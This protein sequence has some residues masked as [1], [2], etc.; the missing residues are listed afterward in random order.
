MAL[1]KFRVYLRGIKFTIVTESSAIRATINNNDIQPQ[2]A[3]WWVYLQDYITFDIVY[4]PGIQFSHVDYL[5]RN[6]IECCAVDLT[7]KEWI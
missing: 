3:R 2:V 4:R 6:P 1:K 7:E 5:S